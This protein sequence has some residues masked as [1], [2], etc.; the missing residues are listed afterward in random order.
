MKEKEQKGKNY[1]EE[2]NDGVSHTASTVVHARRNTKK[3]RKKKR[4]KKRQRGR[5]FTA[6]ATAR[7]VGFWRVVRRRCAGRRTVALSGGG[8]VRRWRAHGD[9][10]RHALCARERGDKEEIECGGGED[11]PP[12]LY[13]STA[14]GDRAPGI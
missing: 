14:R 3:Q 5:R 10:R 12:P 9:E 6:A 1:G 11:F 13:L 4:K 8:S 7:G 2:I